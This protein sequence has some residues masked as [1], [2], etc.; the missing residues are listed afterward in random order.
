LIAAA[1]VSKVCSPSTDANTPMADATTPPAQQRYTRT[2]IIL[3]WTIA[4]LIVWQIG[5]GLWMVPAIEDPARWERALSV[6]QLHKSTGLTVLLLSLARLAWRFMHPPPTV[7]ASMPAW[8]RTVA[9][10][11]HAA[12][13]GLMIAVPLV[14]WLVV[15][16]S[17]LGVST[18]VVGGFAWP[19]LPV[20]SALEP[21]AKVSHRLLGYALG[22]LAVGHVLAALT[23]QF[24]GRDQALRR[25]W[26]H[27]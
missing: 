25:M 16:A 12:L 14:G 2:A 8:Q 7:L 23:H 20:S 15:S 5:S 26:F 10:V 1:F 4:V 18:V 13:Y 3:H 22:G 24:V 19:H 6:Y 17:P 27:R 21:A 9:S 11:G